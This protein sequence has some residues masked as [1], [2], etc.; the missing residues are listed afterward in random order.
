[1]VGANA[2]VGPW[3]L[4]GVRTS[5]AR[6]VAEWTADW[7]VDASAESGPTLKPLGTERPSRCSATNA[8]ARRRCADARGVLRRRPRTFLGGRA[9]ASRESRG[10]M[11]FA[12][13]PGPVSL[14][15]LIV[16]EC[17]PII[18]CPRSSSLVHLLSS[19]R[20]AVERK[21]DRERRR[22]PRPSEDGEP[23]R[24]RRVQPAGRPSSR[25][26][27]LNTEA[28]ADAVSIRGDVNQRE[29]VREPAGSA[30]T[31]GGARLHPPTEVHTAGSQSASPLRSARARPSPE[32]PPW[33]PLRKGGGLRGSDPP[34]FPPYEGGIQGGG[35]AS[36]PE[37]APRKCDA[38]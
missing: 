11:K 2:T 1:V 13:R 6:D 5:C 32:E 21:G 16:G 3:R 9:M 31:P 27:L 25:A 26:V 15:L 33:I 12:R 24:P 36:T 17:R 4:L 18:G 29:L 35:F 20:N 38:L 10:A 14:P 30:S 8:K 22:I 7:T 23:S 19:G 37:S 34:P 28:L